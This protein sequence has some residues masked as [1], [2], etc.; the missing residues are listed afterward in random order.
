MQHILHFLFYF[1]FQITPIS[2]QPDV[3]VP[4]TVTSVPETVTNTAPVPDLVLSCGHPCV[5]CMEKYNISSQGLTNDHSYYKTPKPQLSVI[6]ETPLVPLSKQDCSTPIDRKKLVGKT[7]KFCEETLNSD[8]IEEDVY[9][10][11][12]MLN[13]STVSNS[14]RDD[15]KDLT[16]VQDE[17]DDNSCDE[18]DV[19]EKSDLVLQ[20]KYIC[21]EDCLTDL[22]VRLKC[23]QCDS[24]VDPDDIVK[25]SSDGTLL[26]CW[27]YWTSD[28]FLVIS[29]TTGEDASW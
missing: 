16:Y 6:E 17:S 21:F 10:E 9:D 7:L 8:N 15:S 12:S 3:P 1:T 5:M 4:E 11:D 23:T 28:P 14:F 19:S 22:F 27:I 18:M 29:A 2:T 20:K 13:L 25:D 24:P 26:K